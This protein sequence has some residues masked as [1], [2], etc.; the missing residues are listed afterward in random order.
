MQNIEYAINI[1]LII[2][3]VISYVAMMRLAYASKMEDISIPLTTIIAL[4]FLVIFFWP[5]SIFLNVKVK[6]EDE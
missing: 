6:K 3:F 2:G 4:A 1:Y 5:L